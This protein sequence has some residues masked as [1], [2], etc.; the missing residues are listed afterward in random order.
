MHLGVKDNWTFA[1]KQFMAE[2]N[3]PSTKNGGT[4]LQDFQ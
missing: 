4:I 2:L 3:Q 1:Q